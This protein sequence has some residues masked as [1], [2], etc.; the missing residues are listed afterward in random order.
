MNQSEREV[1][2]MQKL[3]E[4][5]KYENMLHGEGAVFIAGVDE[6]GRGPLAG[7][8]VAAT[9]ILP[10]NFDVLGID[11]SKKVPEKKRLLLET[12]IK[13]S[14]LAY[15]IGMCNEKVIDEINILEATKLA[16]KESI[17]NAE[18]MLGSVV[19]HILLDAV[20]LADVNRPQTA[21]I[22]GDCLSVSIAAASILAKVTRDAM[23]IEYGKRY[24]HYCFEQNKGY[25]TKAHYL[26]I[27]EH[28]FCPIHRRSFLKNYL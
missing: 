14:A 18:K 5:K 24:P 1:Y 7:P 4:M 16:M 26:G 22:H 25:G 3:A 10:E 9:V 20:S 21:I 19:D 13:E 15:G 28:G 2:L 27:E 8:V 12:R 23:M 11:D 6:V 17:F